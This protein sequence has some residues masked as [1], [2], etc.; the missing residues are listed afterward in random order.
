MRVRKQIVA[1][2]TYHTSTGSV[3]FTREDIRHLHRV[4]KAMLADR[5]PVRVPLE[6]QNFAIPLGLLS[7]SGPVPWATVEGDEARR[8]KDVALNSGFVDDYELGPDS[9]LWAWLDIK[10]PEIAKK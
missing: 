7:E 2:G 6:H 3:T 4:G 8:A 9:V 5:L 1:P 10:R